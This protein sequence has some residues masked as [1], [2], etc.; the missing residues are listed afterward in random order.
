MGLTVSKTKGK[1]M[2]QQSLINTMESTF[3]DLINSKQLSLS[4]LR[5]YTL[6]FYNSREALSQGEL[7]TPS[8]ELLGKILGCK[9][10]QISRAMK[11]L[12]E[13]GLIDYKDYRHN[14]VKICI[15]VKPESAAKILAL[16]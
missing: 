6:L 5:L 7:Y 11:K 12:S 8:Q 4:E 15:P 10:P 3:L 9:Q 1:Y 16:H 13:I 2:K 14:G